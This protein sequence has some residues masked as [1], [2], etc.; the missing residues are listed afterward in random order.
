MSG[1][2]YRVFERTKFSDRSL[3]VE[4]T[5]SPRIAKVLTDEQITT[6]TLSSLVGWDDSDLC[7]L[8]GLGQL[9]SVYIH[10]DRTLDFSPILSL[11]NLKE[12][13]LGARCS[14][15]IDL[16][17]L[18]KL[19]FLSLDWCPAFNSAYQLDRLKIL[20]VFRYP[21]EDLSALERLRSVESLLVW[22]TKLLRLKGIESIKNLRSAEFLRCRNL[23]RLEGLGHLRRL[24]ALRFESCKRLLDLGPVAEAGNLEELLIQN[25]GEIDT[26]KPVEKCTRLKSLQVSDNCFVKDGDFSGLKKLSKLRRVLIRHRTHY[27]HRANELER[28]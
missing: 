26:L 18:K 15:S 27:S 11:P 16:T 17:K 28:K 6:L 2:D 24:K 4:K 8:A 3:A 14:K 7:F 23:N 20:K 10:S 25:C 13:S 5:W 1:N 12:L 19:R 21:Y 9:T 22:S